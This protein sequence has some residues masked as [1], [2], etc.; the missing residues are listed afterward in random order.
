[1]NSWID[2]RRSGVLLHVTAL[3]GPFARGVLGLEARQFIDI[4]ADSGFSVWQFLP[5]GPT[6][7]HGSPYESL[8]SSAGNPELLDLRDCVARGWLSEASCSAVIEE[9]LS[10]ETARSEAARG[11]WKHVGEDNALARVVDAFL[12]KNGDWLDDYALFAAL[13]YEYRDLP[14]WQWPE[15][16]RDRSAH[17]LDTAVIEHAAYIRQV[18]FEQFLFAYQWQQLKSH[19]EE[20]G[21]LLFGDIPIYVAHDSADVW[22]D[23]HYF[24]VNQ[25]GVCEKVAGVPPDY[26]SEIGQR[27]GNP[28][29]QWEK[30]QAN[31]FDWWIK[32]IR[33]Q[34]CRM[35]LMRIDHFRGL[36]SYWAIPGE[37]EDGRIGEWQPAPGAKLL[38]S[39]QQEFGQLPLIAE[40]L[41]LIT[42]EVTA[43]R[44]RFG[45]PGMK[46]LQFAFG[47]DSSNPYLPHNHEPAS[48]AYTGTHDNDTS[49]GWFD[50]ASEHEKNH[51]SNYLAISDGEEMPLPLIRAA[52]ASVARLAVI[53]LQDLLAL[54]TEARFNTPGTVEGNWDWRL[55][56][57]DTL[58]ELQPKYREL[59]G[60]YGR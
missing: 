44:E 49:V 59:N 37:M 22:A 24:T 60:L 1:M 16:L 3:P 34:L 48:V 58:M 42:P 23:R 8:S 30:L 39:L 4:I 52:L 56:H 43:L 27:W 35:H 57:F 5:L 55:D 20:R 40:D 9:N 14:W 7:G 10:H 38:E 53:P 17:A 15:A 11:F 32:R 26:F 33:R 18:Q 13:K 31:R 50:A 41:G 28:L 29:Y 51:L 45:L 21:V 47:D 6:H 46:I 19:A 2:R 54:P 36:E 12:T 25:E